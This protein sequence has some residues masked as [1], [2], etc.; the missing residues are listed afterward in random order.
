[1]KNGRADQRALVYDSPVTN[2]ARTYTYAEVLDE[3]A[4]PTLLAALA[5][6]AAGI[7]LVNRKPA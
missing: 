5:L 1:M 4:T 7:V 6:V 2:S 3:V